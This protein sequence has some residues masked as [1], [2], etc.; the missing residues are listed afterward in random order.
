ML[1]PHKLGILALVSFQYFP[2]KLE[3][4]CNPLSIYSCT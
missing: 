3:R 1:T 4:V 2:L